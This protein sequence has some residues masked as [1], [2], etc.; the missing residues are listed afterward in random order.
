MLLSGTGNREL[1]ERIAHEI[2]LPL[3]PMDITRSPTGRFDVKI[4]E[5]VRATTSS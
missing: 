1:S 4:H 2:D 3:A 5:S